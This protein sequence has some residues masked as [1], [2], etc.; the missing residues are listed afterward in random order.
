MQVVYKLV[1]A[2]ILGDTG[3]HVTRVFLC[4]YIAIQGSIHMMILHYGHI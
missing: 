1:N 4:G 2:Q 3:Y